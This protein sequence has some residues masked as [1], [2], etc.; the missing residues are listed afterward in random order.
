[1]CQIFPRS[2]MPGCFW[3]PNAAGN[4]P[5]HTI[6]QFHETVAGSQ[7]STG[8]SRYSHALQMVCHPH[9]LLHLR[10][11]PRAA[12]RQFAMGSAS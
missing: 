5:V 1:M 12:D 2:S 3:L 8:A 6:D 9:T 10:K 11:P 7:Y 4:R